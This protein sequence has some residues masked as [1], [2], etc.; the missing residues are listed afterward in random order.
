MMFDKKFKNYLNH[1]QEYLQRARK[2]ASPSKKKGNGKQ[3]PPLNLAEAEYY[4][5]EEVLSN[6]GSEYQY[7]DAGDMQAAYLEM[8]TGKKRKGGKGEL[9]PPELFENELRRYEFETLLAQADQDEQSAL[10]IS[11]D[12]LL[13]YLFD[14]PI[15]MMLYSINPYQLG[16][17]LA[18][19]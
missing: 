1:R 19:F 8:T 5:E 15:M 17:D 13:N 10:S 6:T 7:Q 14:E 12:R 18:E 9:F 4:N 11:K 2:N 3:K 16:D